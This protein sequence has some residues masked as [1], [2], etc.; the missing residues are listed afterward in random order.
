MALG[1]RA[2]L[3]WSTYRTTPILVDGEHMIEDW[4][5]IVRYLTEFKDQMLLDGLNPQEQA[6]FFNTVERL[7][8]ACFPLLTAPL[9]LDDNLAVHSI[10][11]QV[12]LRGLHKL[13]AFMFR[14]RWPRFSGKFLSIPAHESPE[15]IFVRGIDELQETLPEG[16]EQ[17]RKFGRLIDA[18]ISRVTSAL[19]GS[20]LYTT[21]RS[22]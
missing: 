15:N 8:V 17:K 2:A 9:F 6:S 1:D 18:M 20:D 21:N 16:S 5:A 7:D 13:K 3:S 10:E 11:H 14:I 22:Q 12:K 4:R 19:E